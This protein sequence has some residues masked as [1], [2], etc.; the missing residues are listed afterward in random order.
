MSSDTVS[1]RFP[2]YLG[3]GM[4]GHGT[5]LHSLHVWA[6]LGSGTPAAFASANWIMDGG[7]V[8][9]ILERYILRLC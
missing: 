3:L 9:V 5:L 7:V 6:N 1:V 4:Y 2:F 8:I